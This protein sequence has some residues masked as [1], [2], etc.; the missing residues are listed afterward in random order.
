MSDYNTLLDDVRHLQEEC[1]EA[2]GEDDRL[3]DL[4]NY[5]RDE[6]RRRLEGLMRRI[7]VAST[8]LRNIESDSD[9]DEVVANLHAEF[10]FLYETLGNHVDMYEDEDDFMNDP[11]ALDFLFGGQ[12]ERERDDRDRDRE[13]DR[14]IR[15]LTR[16]RDEAVRQRDEII[17]ERDEL[18]DRIASLEVDRHEMIVA[19]ALA[20]TRRSIEERLEEEDG[21]TSVVST[22]RS[23]MELLDDEGNASVVITRRSNLE[24]LDDDGNAAVASSPH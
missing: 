13:P 4:V 1:R 3:R 8:D 10:D 22:R 14:N 17:R 21:N 7:E 6:A 9:E 11:E 18:R 24:L 2:I 5:D 12:E 20:R 23:N 16:Q 19:M 15:Q